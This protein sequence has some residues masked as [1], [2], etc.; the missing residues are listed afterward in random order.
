VGLP[1]SSSVEQ[2]IDLGH[3]R[4]MFFGNGVRAGSEQPDEIVQCRL[5]A[6][7]GHA[8]YA[9]ECPLLGV[10]RTSRLAR[11]RAAY[12]IAARPAFVIL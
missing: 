2:R 11:I 9:Y 7:S 5:L 1:N 4:T 6:L 12:L 10:K 3:I 8:G